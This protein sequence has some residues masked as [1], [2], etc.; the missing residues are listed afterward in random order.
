MWEPRHLT[1]L[2]ALT[3]C[4]RDSFTLP[5]LSMKGFS[6]I[7]G[8]QRG[9]FLMSRLIKILITFHA[10]RSSYRPLSN[11]V[12][13]VK[14]GKVVPV[15]NLLSTTPWRDICGLR[16]GAIIPDL[17]TRQRKLVSFT[18]RPL[19]RWG[20]KPWGTHCIEGCVGLRAVWIVWGR[21]NFFSHV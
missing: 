14:R 6:H 17:S 8:F 11:Y 16:Y 15:L 20:K 3:A 2:R 4:Y 5:L 1:T 12:H 13:V 18:P 7:L 10:S 21:E 19:Y 9:C